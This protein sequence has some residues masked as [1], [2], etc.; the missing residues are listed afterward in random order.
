MTVRDDVGRTRYVAFR[1]HGGPLARP[2]L[3]GALPKEA[4]LTRYDGTYGILRCLHRDRDA[5]LP[6]LMGIRRIGEREVRVETLA[7][8]GTIRA[9]AQALPATSEASRRSPPRRD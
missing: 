6:V 4:R 3:A 9:A 2:A 5:L 1:L 7:T 8:S